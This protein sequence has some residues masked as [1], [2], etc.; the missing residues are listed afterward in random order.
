MDWG[1][2]KKQIVYEFAMILQSSNGL[3]MKKV[4]IKSKKMASALDFHYAPCISWT[5]DEV[6]VDLIQTDGISISLS[7]LSMFLMEWG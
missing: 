5:G 4:F 3:G 1:W 7:L 2:V 6:S